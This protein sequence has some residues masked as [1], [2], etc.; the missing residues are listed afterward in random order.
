MLTRSA[1]LKSV[2]CPHLHLFDGGGY[3]YFVYDDASRN[4]WESRSV[5]VNRLRDMPIEQWT[6]EGRLLVADCTTPAAPPQR[7]DCP[8]GIRIRHDR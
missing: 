6:A 1:I 5:Y 7:Q 3:W 2:S 4:V 8:A